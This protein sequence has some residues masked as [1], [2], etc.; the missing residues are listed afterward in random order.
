MLDVGP[1][2]VLII[3][4][5]SAIAQEVARIYA[6]RGDSLYLLARDQA[7]LGDLTSELAPRVCGFE[8]A[9]LDQLEENAGRVE[10]AIAA[11]GGLDVAL[12]ERKTDIS[13]IR[14]SCC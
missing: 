5:T 8:I 14:R 11:L 9:D 7:K 4:A 3:G 13:Y 2:R 12:V 10:R 6:E 1:Q